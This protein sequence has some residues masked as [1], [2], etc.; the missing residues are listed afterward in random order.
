MRSRLVFVAVLAA[1]STTATASETVIGG[2]SIN[3]PVP[4]G[5]CELSASNPAD[6]RMVTTI[7][8]LVAKGG[9]KLL[10]MSADCQQLADWRAHKRN[11]LD[12]YGQYQTATAQMDKLVASPEAAI[13]GTCQ[14]LRTQGSQITA[15]QTP[16]IKARIEDTLK[17]VKLNEVSFLGVLDEDTNGCYAAQLQKMQTDNGSRRLRSC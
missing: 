16:D 8:G 3:L 1:V 11:Y 13:K 9:N 17:K 2:V 6:N 7:S 15:N 5:F 10:N 14:E 4:S 12:D